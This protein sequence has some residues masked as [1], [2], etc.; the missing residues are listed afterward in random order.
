MAQALGQVLVFSNSP[1][2]FSLISPCV[3]PQIL[4]VSAPRVSFTHHIPSAHQLSSSWDA[5]AQHRARAALWLSDTP[6][7][8]C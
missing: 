4:P 7:H 5:P 3:Q 2:L 8:P 6:A 1:V